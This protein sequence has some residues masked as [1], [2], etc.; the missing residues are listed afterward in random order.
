[1]DYKG[2]KL[3]D[4]IMLVCRD[5]SEHDNSIGRNCSTAYYQ[6][7]LVDPANNQQLAT[8]RHWA[9]WIEYGPSY[10]TD[11]GR[12]VRDYEITHDPVEFTF[13]NEGF[14]LELL[15]CAGGSSQ[16]GKLSFWNC[17]VS[18]DSKRFKIGINSDML[19]DL[20]KNATF[21]NGLCQNPLMF[22][23][24]SGKVG[25]TTIG[26]NTYVQ[27]IKDR[28]LKKTMKS[29][30][31][32]KFAFGDLVKTPTINEVYLGTITQYYTF[33][34]GR[35]TQYNYYRD[36]YYPDCTITRLAKPITYHVFESIYKETRL[37]DFLCQ[38]N[39]SPYSYPDFKKSC[40][41][42]VIDG[43]IDLD[44]S[45]DYFKEQV[46]KKIYDYEAFADYA[47]SSYRSSDERMLYY[48]LGKSTFGFGFEPFEL[49]EDLM[50]KIKAAGIKY[51]EE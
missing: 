51:V 1:M 6:A 45:E 7:Y 26:S 24:K 2:Y 47:K 13:D 38:Y 3:L 18:R 49:S 20:L 33:D 5:V 37:S 22:I 50:A 10:R 17:I 27:C 11:D 29:T 4:K 23:T 43:K 39:H 41:K 25:M 44:C 35:N 12:W 42:R 14:S 16:G 21:I 31:V 9:K 32:S 46:V 28:D 34:P 48:F 30:M 36:I 40:P 15:D 19:L 8:A